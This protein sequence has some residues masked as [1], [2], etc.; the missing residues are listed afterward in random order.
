MPIENKKNKFLI[1]WVGFKES[2]DLNYND[3]VVVKNEYPT[4]EEIK[5]FKNNLSFKYPKLKPIY[6]VGFY[7][8]YA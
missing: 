8:L 2:K 4:E 5:A 7:R 6:I 3:V 1:H